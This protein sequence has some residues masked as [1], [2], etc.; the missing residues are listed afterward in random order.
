MRKS[1]LKLTF[2]LTLILCLMIGVTA[3]RAEGLT[4]NESDVFINLGKSISL[5]VTGAP[6]GVNA[7]K[8]VWS[9]SD[10][11][12]ATVKNGAV[13]GIAVGSCDIICQASEDESIQVVCHVTV[14]KM[15]QNVAIKEKKLTIS[16]GSSVPVSVT[17]KPEDATNQQL[18]WIS[19]DKTI[20]TVDNQG[21]ITAVGPGDCDITCTSTDGSNKSAKVSVHVPI[22]AA[23]EESV[24]VTEQEGLLIPMG[25]NEASV[26]NITHSASSAEFFFYSV[27]REGL[28]IY[29][30]AAGTATITLINKKDKKDQEVFT[31]EVK[32]SAVFD[33][34]A[35]GSPEARILI[36]PDS[37][38]I[39]LG[40]K[41]NVSYRV[42]GRQDLA[43]KLDWSLFNNLGE[44]P[45][46]FHRSYQGSVDVGNSG[47]W[48]LNTKEFLNP[49]S[50]LKVTV[51]AIG[52]KKSVVA[53]ETCMVN[54]NGALNLSV[55][56]EAYTAQ[57][58]T[59]FRLVFQASGGKAPY[60]FEIHIRR[61][62]GE[63]TIFEDVSLKTDGYGETEIIPANEEKIAI[64]LKV[65]DSKNKRLN[66]NHFITI[67]VGDDAPA[68]LDVTHPFELTKEGYAI[69]FVQGGPKALTMEY[70]GIGLTD[71]EASI[72]PGDDGSFL[73]PIREGAMAMGLF[74]STSLL[75]CYFGTIM[76]GSLT[77]TE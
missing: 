69:R 29:P 65:T 67:P 63:K 25:L 37:S 76:I 8:V 19:S 9:S 74:Q 43:I 15:I 35:E 34:S 4:L 21:T 17:I 49:S 14:L 46:D 55:L 26:L 22:F 54:I 28:H 41:I 32:D 73:I 33:P 77:E 12:V 5:K 71:R 6:E 44:V 24:T 53:R 36:V 52:D 62:G 47:T 59:P 23:A 3:A 57:R 56:S 1:F 68:L 11:D 45:A 64:L 30:L 42:L 60:K 66:F 48:T 70:K 61:E 31:V 27:D 7:K 10:P 2:V 72:R 38:E 40:D 58:N 50:V 20:C 18:S 51:S 39:T 16:R 75:R 13:K